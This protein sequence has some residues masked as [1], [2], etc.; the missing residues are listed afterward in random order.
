MGVL[1]F[2]KKVKCFVDYGGSCRV[3]G[4]HIE[5][6]FQYVFVNRVKGSESVGMRRVNGCR[7]VYEKSVA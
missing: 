7:R 3:T 2:T 1:I 4:I 6:W 5:V